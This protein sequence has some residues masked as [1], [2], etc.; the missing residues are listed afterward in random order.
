MNSLIDLVLPELKREETTVAAIKTKD[1]GKG[2]KKQKQANADSNIRQHRHFLTVVRDIIGRAIVAAAARPRKVDG[3][4][5]YYE[6]SLLA[7]HGKAL[8]Y[9]TIRIRADDSWLFDNP[10]LCKFCELLSHLFQFVL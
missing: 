6:L 9:K 10:L 5:A 4:V 7:R 1:G 3:T 8:I 2:A